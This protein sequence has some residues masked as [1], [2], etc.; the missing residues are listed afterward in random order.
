MSFDNLCKLIAE[1][2]PQ[3]FAEWI[4][5]N[6]TDEFEILKT[7]LSIEPIRADSVTFLRN[8]DRILH[9]E[10]Q[11]IWPTKPPMPLRMLDY[12]VRLYRLY[13]VPIHQAVIVLLP[14]T[15]ESVIQ[16]FF[17]VGNTYH[18]FE[19]IK[20]WEQDPAIFLQDPVLLPFAALAKT[21]NPNVLLSQIA[22]Q[23]QRVALPD[24][25]QE[26]SAYVQLIAGL[27]YDKETLRSIFREETMQE[28]VIYQ[29]ITQGGRLTEGKTLVL[30]LLA[31]RVGSVPQEFVAQVE[32]LSLERLESLA[33]ALLDFRSLT[34]LTN[35]LQS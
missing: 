1:K 5:G 19:V 27:K 21:E 33:E 22:Q 30:R 6:V 18:R 16:D 3:R 4:L 8:A 11:T 31:K 32:A 9:L 26:L 13:Q 17:A 24:D 25:R 20:L 34:D 28:S 35:W 14:P 12:W 15:D 29:D 7:E 2:N 10:F 23:V